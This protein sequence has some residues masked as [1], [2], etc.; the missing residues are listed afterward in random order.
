MR[1]SDGTARQ[2]RYLYEDGL[3]ALPTMAVVLGSPGFW[4]KDP[5]TG[6]DW[7]KILHGEQHLVLH[8]PLPAEGT[9]IGRSRV[10]R[11]WSTRGPT[12]AP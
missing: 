7:V 6:I 8:A 11:R 12:R 9:V 2:L 10:S 3:Q 5:G 4:S 1:G